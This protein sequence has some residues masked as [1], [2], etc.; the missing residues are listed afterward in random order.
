MKSTALYSAQSEFPGDCLYRQL[1]LRARFPD[2]DRTLVFAGIIAQGVNEASYPLL[3][4]LDESEF[5]CLMR[6]CFPGITVKGGGRAPTDPLD[7]YA[8]LVAL[9]LEH[10]LDGSDTMVWLSHAIATASLRS[11][12]LW[13]DLGLPNRAVLSRLMRENYP[14]LAALNVGD[15]KWKKFFYRQLC[16]KADVLICKSPNCA[17]CDDHIMCFGPEEGMSLLPSVASPAHA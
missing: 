2:D 7:E 11:N 1:M 10:R 17:V 8:D 12:H 9:L 14:S 16:E 4:G 3:R 15:M 13:Q 5:Q 6:C